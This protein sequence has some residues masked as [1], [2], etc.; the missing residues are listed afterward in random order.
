MYDSCWE[1]AR[2]LTPNRCAHF[3]DEEL[4]QKKNLQYIHRVVNKGI[5]TTTEKGKFYFF[6]NQ[7]YSDCLALVVHGVNLSSMVG[8]KISKDERDMKKLPNFQLSVL[9][10]LLLSDGGFGFSKRGVNCY[11][12]FKQSLAKSNYVWFVFNLF[13]H[14]CS[15]LPYVS[16]SIRNGT[17]KKLLLQRFILVLTLL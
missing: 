13:S 4:K 1:T 8:I 10:G 16:S 14:Y 6:Q 2:G 12:Y 17:V 11:F 9:V 5:L 3:S 7:G 15:S